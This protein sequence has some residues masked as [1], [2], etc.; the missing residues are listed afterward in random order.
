[1]DEITVAKLVAYVLMGL[2][3]LC[4]AGRGYFR[5]RGTSQ[6]NKF[7]KIVQAQARAERRNKERARLAAVRVPRG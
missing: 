3:I 5:L 1:M 6:K 2:C 4:M 7:S